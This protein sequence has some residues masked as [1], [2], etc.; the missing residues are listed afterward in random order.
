MTYAFRC[1]T[2]GRLHEDGIAGEAQTPNKCSQCGAGVTFDKAGNKAHQRD[3][4][5][6][7][8]SATPERLASL[9]LT[10]ADVVTHV[11]KPVAQ[12]YREDYENTLQT[13]AVLNAKETA[14]L[15]S[16]PTAVPAWQALAAQLAALPETSGQVT[17]D[18]LTVNAQRA[19][20][21]AQMHALETTEFGAA[22]KE[23]RLK[24]QAR[25]AEGPE[26]PPPHSLTTMFVRVKDGALAPTVPVAK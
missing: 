5:E 23:H 1:K 3:N 11:K 26:K 4:W 20:L 21:K 14:W 6:I 2:C 10:A 19:T 7:L 8:S 18:D 9:G 22:N 24:L 16:A 17:E 13:L 25:I 12:G 15:Q